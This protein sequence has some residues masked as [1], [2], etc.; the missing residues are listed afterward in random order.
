M[1]AFQLMDRIKGIA[2]FDAED[3]EERPVSDKYT[4]SVFLLYSICT[5]TCT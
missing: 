1:D 4:H 2:G 3:T 5:C